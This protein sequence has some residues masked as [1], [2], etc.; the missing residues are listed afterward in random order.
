MFQ[1]SA[2]KWVLAA[3]F[4]AVLFVV[5]QTLAMLLIVSVFIDAMMQASGFSLFPIGWVVM[6]TLLVLLGR[7]MIYKFGPR[8][9]MLSH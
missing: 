7:L 3:I 2:S 4:A 1:S 6:Y 9:R 8:R 5:P